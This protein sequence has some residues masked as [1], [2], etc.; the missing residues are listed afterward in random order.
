MT[1][2][3]RNI[4]F[5]TWRS[6]QKGEWQGILRNNIFAGK[7]NSQNEK[8]CEV[9]MTHPVTENELKFELTILRDFIANN[10]YQFQRIKIFYLKIKNMPNKKDEECNTIYRRQEQ[11]TITTKDFLRFE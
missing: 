2:N 4:K 8:S 5:S 9:N 3:E 6:L 1:E 7:R 10:N 11:S